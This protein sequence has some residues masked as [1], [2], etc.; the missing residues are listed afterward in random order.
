MNQDIALTVHAHPTL[1][2]MSMEAKS[3]WNANPHNVIFS[4]T[5]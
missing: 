1:G 3:N 4:Q 2:E 5:D